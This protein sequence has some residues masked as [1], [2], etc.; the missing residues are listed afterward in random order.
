M[1]LP[2]MRSRGPGM[3]P[4]VDGVANRRV[5][6]ARAFRAHVALGGEAGH[7]VVLGRLLGEDHAPRNRLL[8]GLQIFRAG[9]QKQMNVRVDQARHQGRIAEVD[10]LCARRMLDADL[11]TARM[12]SP[13][14]RISPGCEHRSRYRPEAAARMQHN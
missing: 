1:A 6:R 8:H 11:P 3:M 10:D 7:H 9:M 2:L 12:R 4:L 14:T 13:S 5:G